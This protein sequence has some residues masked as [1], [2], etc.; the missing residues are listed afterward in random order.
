MAASTVQGGGCIWGF[1]ASEGLSVPETAQEALSIPRC[2]KRG[3]TFYVWSWKEGS[4]GT[5]KVGGQ[6]S[7][8]PESS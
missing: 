8:D 5:G 7:W 1:G 4:W 2:V 3:S 6:R